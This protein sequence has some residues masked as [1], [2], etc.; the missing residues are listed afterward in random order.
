MKKYR[1]GTFTEKRV[2]QYNGLYNELEQYL[3]FRN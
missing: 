1:D 2:L 3:T